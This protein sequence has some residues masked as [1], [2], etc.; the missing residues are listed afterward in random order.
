[1]EKKTMSIQDA[2]KIIGISRQSAY[3]A[4]DRGEIPI[5]RIGRR[6]L[7]PVH[8]LERFLRGERLENENFI[9]HKPTE[10]EAAE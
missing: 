1:M 6:K 2:A 10:A 5:L 3:R 9:Q 7:V 4:V 8:A